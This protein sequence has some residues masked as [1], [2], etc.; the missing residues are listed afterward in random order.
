MTEAER[1]MMRA[2]AKLT[3]AMAKLQMHQL[4]GGAT[5]SDYDDVAQAAEALEAAQTTE[6]TEWKG[7]LE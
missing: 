3:L 5:D 1:E 2:T 7:S 4:D 6:A